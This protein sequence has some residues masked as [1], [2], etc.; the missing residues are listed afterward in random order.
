MKKGFNICSVHNKPIMV[1][2][3]IHSNRQDGIERQIFA[4]CDDNL[5]GQKFEEGEAVI[6]LKVYESFYKGEHVSAEE[7][8]EYATDYSRRFCNY[9]LVGKESI[10]IVAKIVKIDEPN[11]KKIGGIPHLQI[12]KV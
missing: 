12:F 5:L 2:M 8:L 11:V 6:D 9:N 10:S 3:K 1:W 4:M 7:A